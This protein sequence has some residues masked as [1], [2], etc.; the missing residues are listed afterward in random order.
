MGAWDYGPFDNDDASDFW[1][2]LRESKNP[3]AEIEKALKSH[4]EGEQN[5]R[6]AA[7]A[8][9]KLL[10]QFDGRTLR[11][12]KREAAEALKDMRHN[13]DFASEWKQPAIMKRRLDK[14]I[15]DLEK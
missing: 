10:T 9:I 14:E 12:L 13:C 11:R 3:T 8:M 4:K 7:A 6:R 15:K 5:K 1:Y 2:V